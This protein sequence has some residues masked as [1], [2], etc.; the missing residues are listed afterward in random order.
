MVL[1][2]TPLCPIDEVK[3]IISLLLE[4]VN[5]VVQPR[6][7][8]ATQSRIVVRAHTVLISLASLLGYVDTFG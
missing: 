8:S 5:A 3:W 6:P 2:Q 4:I 1:I 7:Q